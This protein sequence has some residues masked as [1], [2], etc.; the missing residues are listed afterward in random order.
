MSAAADL[1]FSVDVEAD[2]PVP[3]PYSM[4]AIGLCVAGRYDG[5]RFESSDPRVDTFYAELRPISDDWSSDALSVSG[6]DRARLA[7]EGREPAEAMTAAA[8]WVRK[9]AGADRPVMV[10]FPLVFDWMFAYWY[11]ERFAHGGSPFGFS[12]GLD[13]KTMYQQKARVVLSEA[14]KDDLP[15]R[16]RGTSPHRHQAL[17]D[18]VEQAEIF[19]RLFAW[20]GH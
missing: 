8:G 19:V 16:L 4:L 13:M 18:A 17:D 14:G 1:F 7:E 12:S 3:G 9:C 11:F 10:G 6:L 5:E 20:D 15:A 2:G